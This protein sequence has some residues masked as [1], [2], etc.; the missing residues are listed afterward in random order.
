MQKAQVIQTKRGF[1]PGRPEIPAKPGVPEGTRSYSW[2]ESFDQLREWK[3]RGWDA[4]GVPNRSKAGIAARVLYRQM[5]DEVATQIANKGE[6]PEEVMLGK[7]WQNAEKMSDQSR[8]YTK[9]FGAPGV[10][11]RGKI[12]A[13]ALQ[14][15]VIGNNQDSLMEDVIETMG[16]EQGN[17][18]L[19]KVIHG[20]GV[21]APK[22][23]QGKA[24]LFLRPHGIS[25]RPTPGYRGGIPI[26]AGQGA[27]GLYA[28]LGGASMFRALQEY[29]DKGGPG[30]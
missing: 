13:A 29:M 12:N 9:I 30:Q 25:I 20:G 22:D 21:T 17:V 19:N 14:N 1:M 10:I 11:D 5:R 2:Q 8:L 26:D 7:R 28:R 24:N 27:W 18:F 4:H 23:L 3:D 16:P 15:V 6:T